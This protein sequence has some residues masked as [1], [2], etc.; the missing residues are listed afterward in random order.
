MVDKKFYTAKNDRMFKAIF[1]NEDNTY[2]F[3]EF[4][5]RLLES[6]VKI[7]RYLRNEIEVRHSSSKSK[8]VDILAE[9]D[10]KIVHIEINS[11]YNKT[12]LH[13]RN[14][15]TEVFDKKTLRGE[16]YIYNDDFIHIDL[17]YKL[18][19]TFNK[20]YRTYYVMDKDE[21]KYIE[22]FKILEFNMDRIMEFWYSKDIEKINNFLHLIILDLNLEEIDELLKLLKKERD[23]LFFKDFKEKLSEL[24]KDDYF[25]SRISREEDLM[26]RANTEKKIAYNEGIE[27]GIEYNKIETAKNLKELNMDTEQI[28]KVTGLS[29]EEIEKISA[30]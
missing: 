22:D 5:S 15:I 19:N 16:D 8:T 1:C 11:E 21:N 13:I 6:D 26:R 23:V 18:P 24:N 30:E 7:I 10:K 29:I 28:S 9:V 17:T 27:Q 4:L 14:F 25:V 3:K 2:L 20:V 12:Y